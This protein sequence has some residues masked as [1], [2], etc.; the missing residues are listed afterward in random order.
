[1]TSFVNGRMGTAENPGKIVWT[2]PL[3]VIVK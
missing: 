2:R 3:F 1:M